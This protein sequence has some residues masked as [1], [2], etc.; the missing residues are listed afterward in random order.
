MFKGSRVLRFVGLMEI[1]NSLVLFIVTL[2][3]YFDYVSSPSKFYIDMLYKNFGVIRLLIAATELYKL[4]VA[5]YAAVRAD[6]I[7]S[8][9]PLLVNSII[10]AGIS[11]VWMF[12]LVSRYID[13]K[14]K[15]PLF[16]PEYN[17]TNEIILLVSVGL[18]IA[19]MVL[20]FAGCVMN[21]SKTV[22]V[23]SWGEGRGLE[24]YNIPP[25]QVRPQQPQ[26]PQYPQYPQQP[27]YQPQQNYAPQQDYGQQGYYQQDGYTEQYYDE[28]TYAQDGYYDGYTEQYT[29][30]YYEQPAQNEQGYYPQED[31]NGGV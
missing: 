29:Q 20:L 19:L 13:I 11:G 17:M 4:I 1:A 12:Y 28:N 2:F 5:G 18:D 23:N 31:E 25:T 9:K 30:D 8:A 3:V 22:V 24:K 27:Q 10:L 15:M 6:N 16:V 21:K 26:Y 14:D 7:E